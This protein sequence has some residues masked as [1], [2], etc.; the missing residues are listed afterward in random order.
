VR[1][2]ERRGALVLE[3]SPGLHWLLGLLFV[4]VGA[5]FV[6]GGFGLA[7]DIAALVWWERALVIVLGSIAAGVGLWILGRSPYSRVHVDGRAG[8]IRMVRYA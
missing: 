4:G 2:V 6:L 1:L 7:S 8:R 5:L 3:D